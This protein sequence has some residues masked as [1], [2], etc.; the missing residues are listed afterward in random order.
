MQ[1]KSSPASRCA[2]PGHR[3][4]SRLRLAGS[5]RCRQRGRERPPMCPP[6]RG[7][8]G[9]QQARPGTGVRTLRPRPRPQQQPMASRPG[10]GAEPKAVGWV[11]A[12]DVPR[13]ATRGAGARNESTPPR[14]AGVGPHPASR[15]DSRVSAQRSRR[16][17]PS[18]PLVRSPP[19][20]ARSSQPGG[21]ARRRA[22]RATPG[23]AAG[24][25]WFRSLPPP[26]DH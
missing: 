18:H 24:R 16:S 7:G 9:R 12:Q 17:R 14:R 25:R 19:G 1:A 8:S 26:S 22:R 10:C 5:S 23:R 4:P 20:A 2:A 11:F 6:V 13:H 21:R 15:P 3:T